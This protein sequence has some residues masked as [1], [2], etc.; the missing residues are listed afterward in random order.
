M[1]KLFI[2]A[3]IALQ[4]LICYCQPVIR[5]DR[6][7]MPSVKG[8][9]TQI[10]IQMPFGK[11]DISHITGDTALLK[12]AG[13]IMVDVVC[14]EYP[15]NLSLTELNSNRLRSFLKMFPNI[16]NGQLTAVNIYRQLNGSQKQVAD[17]MFHGLVVTFRPRQTAETMRR[18]VAK[19]DEMLLPVPD[20]AYNKPQSITQTAQPAIKDT[21]AKPSA[22]VNGYN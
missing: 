2:A 15:S 18:D 17:T 1:R 22:P 9:Q 8:A 19:L 10:V 5:I 16:K 12:D 20:S 7:N 14:T 4:P 3:L 21:V 13:D 11:A 6:Y